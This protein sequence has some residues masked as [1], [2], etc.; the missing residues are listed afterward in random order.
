MPI[1][2]WR[3]LVRRLCLRSVFT[4]VLLLVL[5]IVFLLYLFLI[6]AAW[7]LFKI[8]AR[9]YPTRQRIWHGR[10]DAS[11]NASGNL[12]ETLLRR[13]NSRRYFVTV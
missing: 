10:V 11:Q 5:N 2:R 3:R 6:F 13:K 12:M 8:V 4:L 9:V 7:I 1:C